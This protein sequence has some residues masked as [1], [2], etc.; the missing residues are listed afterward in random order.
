M[1][2]VQAQETVDQ[3]ATALAP[4]PV[5]VHHDFAQTPDFRLRSPNAAFVPEPKRTGW[6]TWGFTEAILHSIDFALRER[7]FDYLQI[8]SPTCLPIKP[9][10][11]FASHVADPAH[12]AHFGAI[13]LLDDRDAL[14]W[15]GYRAFAKR[16][17][18]RFRA[19]RYLSRAYFRGVSAKREIAGV[20]LRSGVSTNRLGRPTLVSRVALGCIIANSHPTIGRHVFDAGFRPHFGSVWFGARREVVTRLSEAARDVRLRACFS[21]IQLPEEF[22]FSSLLARASRSPGTLNHL[23]NTFE[24]ANPRWLTDADFPRLQRSEAFFARKFADDAAAPLRLRVLS[25]LAA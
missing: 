23:V 21:R 18:F 22:L 4:H 11:A 13:D 3:L 9:L 15:V 17:T 20:W 8:L 2:A 24:E 16:D 25:E 10:A 14:M 19:L 12:D 7:A 5:L 6:G 1:S